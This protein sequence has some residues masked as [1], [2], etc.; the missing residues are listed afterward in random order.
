MAIDLGTG[1]GRA[2]L[3]LAAREPETLV[4]GVDANASSMAEASRRA[5]GP[6]RKGGRPNARFVIAAAELPPASLTGLAH[7]VTVRFPWGSLLQGSLGLDAAVA[8]GIASL[9]AAR[10]T[11]ELLLAPSSRDGLEG[12]P[13]AVPDVA[14]AVARTFEPFGFQLTIGR[15]A[16]PAEIGASGSTWAKRLG[17]GSGDRA[18]TIV[19]LELSGRAGHR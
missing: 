12:L 3:H 7:L 16:T 9:V 18:V 19:R 6:A 1:D 10:G 4:L 13:T 15:A 5:A 17:A 14:A 11:L 8:T 2:V